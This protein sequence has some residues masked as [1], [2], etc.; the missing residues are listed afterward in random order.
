MAA[1]DHVTPINRAQQQQVVETTR[2][3][4]TLG[5]A[6]FGRPFGEVPVLFNLRG[7]TSGMYRVRGERRE[8]RYNPWIFALHYEESLTVTVP[9]EVAHYLTDRVYGLRNIRPHG[10]EWKALM[11]VFGADPS[12]TSS[13]SLAGIPQ[14]RVT[15]YTYHCRCGSHQLGPQRHRRILGGRSLY[16]CRRCDDVLRAQP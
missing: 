4:I 7:K 8:I 5:E 11:A 14:R 3:F 13:Y 1:M 10:R 6:H 16:R 15:T 9:H 12:V 2:A